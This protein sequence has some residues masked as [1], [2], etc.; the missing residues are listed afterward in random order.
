MIPKLQV[1]I[2]ASP[3]I[4]RPLMV[5][6]LTVTVRNSTGPISG[7]N[8]TFTSSP[9]GTFS[10]PVMTSPGTYVANFTAPIVSSTT[11]DV[12]QV[13]ASASGY[14]NAPATT[15]IIIV[16]QLQVAIS[17]STTIIIPLMVSKLPM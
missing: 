12:I 14:I 16:Q 3:T 11:S 6:N 5:S 7:A 15:T 17:A 8:L 13:V 4:L 2:S 1:A 9:L 10:Q